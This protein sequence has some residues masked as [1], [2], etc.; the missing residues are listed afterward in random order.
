MIDSRSL[1]EE[2][3]RHYRAIDVPVARLVAKARAEGHTIPCKQGCDACCYDVTH[4]CH[5]ELAPLIER[6]RQMP[7]ALLDEIETRIADWTARMKAGGLEPDS[8]PDVR[9]Y[10]RLHL[11]CPL[12]D[13]EKHECRVYAVR[14]VACRCYYLINDDPAVCANRANVP[15]VTIMDHRATIAG[16][17]F[18]WLERWARMTKRKEVPVID[19]ML[20]FWLSEAW[21]IVRDRS[22]SIVS[23]MLAIEKRFEALQAVMK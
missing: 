23:W 8:L 6:L 21:P 4:V 13:L 18:A 11:A 5:F 14:P 15:T 19:A 17:V 9:T 16:P 7:N 22:H 12:L 10:H 2:T 3:R 1:A 20:P